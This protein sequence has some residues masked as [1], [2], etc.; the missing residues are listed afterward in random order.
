MRSPST[1]T[2][3]LLFSC[4]L[5]W[6]VIFTGIGGVPQFVVVAWFL[7]AC[8]GMMLARFLRLR[9]PLMQWTLAITLSFAADTLVGCLAIL[10]GRWSPT[11]IISLLVIA[12]AVGALLS[13]VGEVRAVWKAWR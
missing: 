6:F 11:G 7:C 2:L 1:W 10:L 3:V 5:T 8:P 4:L 13:E 9:E 12:T